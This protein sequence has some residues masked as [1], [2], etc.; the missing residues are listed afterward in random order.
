MFASMQ[1]LN[2]D[3]SYTDEHT[4]RQRLMLTVV[5]RKATFYCDL[6]KSGKKKADN[7]MPCLF[8]L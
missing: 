1:K 4:R 6:T 2:T 7:D 8:A 3:I 5:G